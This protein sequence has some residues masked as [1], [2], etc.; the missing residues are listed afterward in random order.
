MVDKLT[1]EKLQVPYD[2]LSYRMR[3][4]NGWIY[5]FHSYRSITSQFI[6]DAKEEESATQK[7][8]LWRK[9]TSIIRRYL[10]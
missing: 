3:V 2:Y 9:L 5:I 6:P 1:T 4:D 10:P 8:Y 7:D